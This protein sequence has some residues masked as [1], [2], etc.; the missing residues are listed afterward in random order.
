MDIV[1][2][3]TEWAKSEVFSAR[4]VWLFSIIEILSGLGFGYFGRTPMAKAFVWPML[5][6][7]LFIA[8]VGAGL[9]FAN[10]PRIS[11]FEKEAS[12]KPDGFVQSET[13]RT[14][15][16]KRDLALVFRILPIV[17]VLASIVILVVPPSIW[18]SIAIV[19]IVNAAFLMVVDSNTE[20]RN[21]MYHSKLL[22]T[23]K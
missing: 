6:A 13:Q 16:S 18:R 8:A 3:S 15:K 22:G 1:S 11:Q 17:I 7:G 2:L 20:A 19:A 14:G 4:I 5:V 12:I 23:R 21:N 9:Y 10:S